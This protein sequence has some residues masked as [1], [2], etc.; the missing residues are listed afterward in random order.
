MLSQL[1]SPGGYAGPRLRTGLDQV[2]PNT[3]IVHTSDSTVLLLPCIGD[4]CEMAPVLAAGMAE[5][6]RLTTH[7]ARLGAT[8]TQKT[9]MPRGHSFEDLPHME[10]A[11]NMMGYNGEHC[12]CAGPCAAVILTRAGRLLWGSA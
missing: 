1:V 3:M 8:N 4:V 12:R 5:E 7:V 10:S 2:P 6:G 9:Y 11:R